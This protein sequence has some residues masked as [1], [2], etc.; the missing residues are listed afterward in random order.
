[1]SS[2]YLSN[3]ALNLITYRDFFSKF[4]CLHSRKCF[5]IIST[6]YELIFT[7]IYN[8]P[9]SIVLKTMGCVGDYSHCASSWP[10]KFYCDQKDVSVHSGQILS[11][12]IFS[13]NRCPGPWLNIKMSYYQCRKSYCGDETILWLYYLHNMISY[14]GEMA[15]LYWIGVQLSCSIGSDKIA[16]CLGESI[17][18]VMRDFSGLIYFIRH[19]LRVL[20]F[21]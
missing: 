13:L 1:M 3:E 15:S 16:Q 18:W 8:P 6:D 14:T 11:V 5:R 21:F 7:S 4:R 9:C 2:I 17:I 10:A 19:F 20:Y 12:E